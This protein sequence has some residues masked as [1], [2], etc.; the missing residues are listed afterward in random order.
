MNVMIKRS[1]RGYTVSEIDVEK[2]F[3]VRWDNESGGY[4]ERHAGY[5]LYG[6]ISYEVGKELVECSGRHGYYKNDMKVM[7][8]ACYNQKPPFQEGY[9]YLANLAGPKPIFSFGPPCTKRILKVLEK[10]PMERKQLRDMLFDEGYPKS[11]IAGALK[12]MSND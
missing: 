7:I 6:Y 5:S 10:G 12:H 8:P 9:R 4:H 3:N 11:R 2:I 1:F